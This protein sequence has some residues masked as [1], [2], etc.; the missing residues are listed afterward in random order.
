MVAA[1][2]AALSFALCA[3]TLGPACAGTTT[4]TDAGET[5]DGDG[6]GDGIHDT[7]EDGIA[8]QGE[9]FEVAIMTADPSPPDRGNNTWTLQVTRDDA[10]AN[11]LSVTVTPFMPAHNHGTTPADFTAEAM[12]DTDGMYTVGPFDLFMPGSWS[13]LV[14]VSDG[15]S[16]D[17]VEF[18]FD[19]VG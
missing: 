14:T 19:I 10:P 13:L 17:E 9:V 4:G 5:G 18:F 1:R 2:F 6:D 12:P 15:E 3:L 16:E 8:K 7:Y 11:D